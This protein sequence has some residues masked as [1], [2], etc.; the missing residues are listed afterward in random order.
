MEALANTFH[1]KNSK[2]TLTAVKETINNF[3]ANH[4]ICG[5]IETV[6][7]LQSLLL[8]HL[9][10]ERISGVIN[11]YA[12]LYDGGTEEDLENA[13]VIAERKDLYVPLFV[14]FIDK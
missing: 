11:L 10:R 14:N 4:S 2:I 5:I 1:G 12:V 7:I 3:K 13:L 6:N 8:K 9:P